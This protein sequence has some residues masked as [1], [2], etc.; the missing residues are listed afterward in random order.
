MN[1]SRRRNELTEIIKQAHREINDFDDAKRLKENAG[2]AGKCFR[3]RNNY[4]CPEKP[5]DYWWLYLQVTEVSAD[6]YLSVWTFEQD[7]YGHVR[8][9]APDTRPY[10]GTSYE[11]I[12]PDH[13]WEMWR[14]LRQALSIIAAKG[15]Y[16]D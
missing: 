2:M 3:T 8:I 10:L 4:S 12:T 13:F 14:A 1:E 15:G 9:D 7:T 5:D 11:E 6:G 16:H